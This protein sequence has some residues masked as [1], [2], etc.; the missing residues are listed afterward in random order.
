MSD[1]KSLERNDRQL[2]FHLTIIDGIS[3]EELHTV[4]VVVCHAQFATALDIHIVRLVGIEETSDVSSLFDIHHQEHVETSHNWTSLLY[5]TSSVA[6][7][8][9]GDK[10]AELVA[11]VERRVA[12]DICNVCRTKHIQCSSHIELFE[13]SLDDGSEI[14][15][16]LSI[17]KRLG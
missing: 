16:C 4:K 17:G 8:G 9:E 15:E 1:G 5:H 13:R 3:P 14:D 12:Q 11:G 6:E 2:I 10:F 7:V